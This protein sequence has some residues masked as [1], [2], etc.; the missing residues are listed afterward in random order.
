MVDTEKIQ[1]TALG[2]G[3]ILIVGAVHLFDVFTR[4]YKGAINLYTW[5]LFF[6]LYAVIAYRLQQKYHDWKPILVCFILSALVMPLLYS[7]LAQYSAIAGII[8]VFNPVWIIYLLFFHSEEYPWISTIYL[9][10]WIM[11][12]T[13]SFMPQIQEYAGQQGYTI[14]TISPAI[15]IRYLVRATVD[16]AYHVWDTLVGI[17]ETV[18]KEV[19]RSIKIASGDYYTG[20]VDEGAK[21]ML[22]VFIEPLKAAHPTFYEGEPATVYSTLKAETMEDPLDIK[23]TCT[24]DKITADQVIPKKEFK[25]YT[26]EEQAI[27]CIFKDLK[28]KSYVFKLAANFEFTTRAYKRVYLIEKDRLREYRREGIDP[29]AD[30]PQKQTKTIYTA[31]PVMIGVG[32]GV[33]TQPVGIAYTTVSEQGPTIGVTID[34]AW[35]GELKKIEYLILLTPKGM[36]IDNINGIEVEATPCEELDE[37][38]AE[39]CDDGVETAYL[40]PK[41]LLDQVNKEKDIVGFTFRAFTKITD[42]D[43]LMG[44]DPVSIRNIKVTTRYDYSYS[45]QRSITVEK[46]EATT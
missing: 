12:L 13:F 18:E 19:E 15:T 8:M 21:K 11:L 40:L 3:I 26:T 32:A 5:A 7:L 34:N 22:G 9:L 1:S 24:A 30:F 6:A 35:I 43:D 27:D 17:K 29:L 16:A 2:I 45:T 41:K 46:Q 25:V 20:Q 38:D 28:A 10:F 44:E 33:E 23:L 39:F 37:K 36:E 31:G 4:Y 14:P 42:F